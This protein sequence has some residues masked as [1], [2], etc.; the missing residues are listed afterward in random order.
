[1][2]NT[3]PPPWLKALNN[4]AAPAP[5]TEPA[6]APSP[7]SD[8]H[9]EALP[10]YD[11]PPPLVFSNDAQMQQDLEQDATKLIG[12]G[13]DPISGQPLDS[14]TVSHTAL[15]FTF[16]AA[17]FA[18]SITSSN[19]KAFDIEQEWP[20]FGFSKPSSEPIATHVDPGYRYPDGTIEPDKI[21]RNKVFGPVA[22]PANWNQPA[23][24]VVNDPVPVT[25]PWLAGMGTANVIAFDN[26]IKAVLA[27][28][29]AH[30]AILLRLKGWQSPYFGLLDT[31]EKAEQHIAH[32]YH[33]QV[34]VG[35]WQDKGHAAIK[36]AEALLTEELARQ[37]LLTLR[38]KYR[39]FVE[40]AR[41]EWKA[42]I[43]YRRQQVDLLNLE[44]ANKHEAFKV[45]KELTFEEWKVLNDQE[46]S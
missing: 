28:N 38:H 35:G 17:A 26:H 41:K 8:E 30:A 46:S 21:A 7:A 31:P 4:Q 42:A 9:V 40:A 32:C 6:A 18:E 19:S 45:A 33:K 15:P 12:F 1:M 25:A 24:P 37:E 16:D 39:E 43:E 34:D 20:V 27:V 10:A 29:P 44:V 36:K 11:A 23:E 13:I 3:V 22:V 5:H 2:P 14:E